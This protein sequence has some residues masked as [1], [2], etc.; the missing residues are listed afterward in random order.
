V[1]NKARLAAQGFSQVEGLEFG[2]TFTPLQGELGVC[3][4]YGL[5]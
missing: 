3:H 2:E 1:R 5:V 4:S